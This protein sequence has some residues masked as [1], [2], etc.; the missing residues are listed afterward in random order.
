MG[1]IGN[2]S[3]EPNDVVGFI[4]YQV[5]SISYDIHNTYR[6]RLTFKTF[7]CLPKLVSFYRKK[8]LIKT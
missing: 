1:K 7:H 8:G 6:H 5:L 4:S 2:M 3:S